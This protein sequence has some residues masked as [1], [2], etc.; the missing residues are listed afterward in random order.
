LFGVVLKKDGCF[1]LRQVYYNDMSVLRQTKNQERNP[2]RGPRART[3]GLMMETAIRLMQNGDTPSV[4]NV[5]DAAEVSRATAYRYFPSQAELIQD[6]VEEALG[7]IIRWE[8]TELNI[9]DRLSDFFESSL[10]RII[11]FETT[12]RAALQHSL[13][14]QS[15]NSEGTAKVEDEFKRGHRIDL[16]RKA[17]DPL[18]R[19]LSPR[20][21]TNLVKALSLLFGIEAIVVLKDIAHLNSKETQSTI[22]WAANAM[23]QKA[24]NDAKQG[25]HI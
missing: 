23:V 6:V 18:Q 3:R 19:D 11:E 8:S 14:R 22:Q 2:E 13:D 9:D 12:F 24:L 4:S 20:Q 5:A 17:I 7:P 10:P 21:M 25:D 16:L 15:K 1:F